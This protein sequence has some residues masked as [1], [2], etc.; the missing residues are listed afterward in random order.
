MNMNLIH[1]YQLLSTITESA[2][3]YQAEYKQYILDHKNKVKQVA[4]WLKTNC[5]EVFKGVSL[6]SFDDCIRKH[7]DSKFSE[8]EFEAYAKFWAEDSDDY[9]WDPEYDE[10]VEHHWQVNEHHPEHWF[11]ADM[12]LLYILEMICDWGS[13][14]IGKGNFEELF[15]FYYEEAQYDDEKDLSP[16]TKKII[17][18]ILSKI[19]KAGG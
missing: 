16:K 5:P 6:A 10:A 8:P 15:D 7:D 1:A 12:P 19:K 9:S 17:E 3:D 14:S 2:E 13:F 4:D 11:G 18:D